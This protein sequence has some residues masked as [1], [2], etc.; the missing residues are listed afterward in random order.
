MKNL[1]S[2]EVILKKIISTCVWYY[3]YTE[4][5]LTLILLIVFFRSGRYVIV[6]FALFLLVFFWSIPVFIVS[7]M[8]SLDALQKQFSFMEGGTL[9]MLGRIPLLDITGCY[10]QIIWKMNLNFKVHA[11]KRFY[12][13]MVM[14]ANLFR[15]VLMGCCQIYVIKNRSMII[16]V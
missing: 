15:L 10:E 11:T 12:V 1:R 7:S 8:V 13:C 5:I 6:C 14:W 9:R 4:Y 3:I 2:I 16:F